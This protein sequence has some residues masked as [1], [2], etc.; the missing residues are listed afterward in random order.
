MLPRSM[1]T[2]GMIKLPLS[3]LPENKL[4]IEQL[5]MIKK[6]RSEGFSQPTVSFIKNKNMVSPVVTRRWNLL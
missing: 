3:S 2:H 1:N 4:S 5:K 6:Y